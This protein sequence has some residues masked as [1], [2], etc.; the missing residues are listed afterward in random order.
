MSK[1]SS[2]EPIKVLY[3]AGWGRSGST[4]LARILGEIEGFFH[5]GEL[6]TIWVDGLKPHAICGCG[7]RVRECPFWESVF[8][9]AFGGIDKIEAPAMTLLRRS[10]EPRTQE[11]F[12][13]RFLPNFQS[14]LKIRLRDYQQ[15]LEGLY[16]GI[17]TV[18]GSRVIVDDSNHPGY[19]YTLAMMPKIELT[20]V[21]LIRDPR[22]TAYSWTQRQKKGLGTYTIRDNSLGWLLRNS[23]TEL[24]PT[25]TAVKYLRLFYEDFATQPKTAVQKILNLLSEQP[26]CLPFLTENEVELG[27]SHSIFGNPNRTKTGKIKIALDREWKNKLN[28][29]TKA[30]VAALTF[31][32]FV[33][34][35]YFYK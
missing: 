10:S 22:A 32:L 26:S 23:V 24:L 7:A 21:H 34:Y 15:V 4:I 13:A 28:P 18:T 9:V 5:G 30:T 20:I 25:T 33:K 6:R 12:L 1:P 14:Q 11:I 27:I 2:D 3:I 16:R 29:S 8:E 17:Q 35:G 19:A 31:P